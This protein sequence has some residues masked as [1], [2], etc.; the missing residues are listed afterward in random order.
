MKINF[1]SSSTSMHKVTTYKDMR[2]YLEKTPYRYVPL[3]CGSLSYT[4]IAPVNER[5][6][7]VCFAPTLSTSSKLAM[8]NY[9]YSWP[10]IALL[11]CY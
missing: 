7:S 3:M 2:L 8:T 5:S 1:I 11:H 10:C 4:F 6:I 9:Y